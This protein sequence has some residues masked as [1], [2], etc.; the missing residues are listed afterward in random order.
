MHILTLKKPHWGGKNNKKTFNYIQA[1]NEYKQIFTAKHGS[2]LE[3]RTLL[4]GAL[5]RLEF[6]KVF[7]SSTKIVT[8]P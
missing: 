3:L 2:G 5:S 1:S 4:T 6:V 7:P 8:F